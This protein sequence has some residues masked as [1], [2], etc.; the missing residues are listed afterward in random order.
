MPTAKS[1]GHP[2]AALMR[3]K[4]GAFSLNQLVHNG[5]TSKPFAICHYTVPTLFLFPLR[6]IID[7]YFS[8]FFALFLP[9][10]IDIHPP[11][12]RPRLS[13]YPV[14][15]LSIRVYTHADQTIDLHVQ[16]LYTYIIR[17]TINRLVKHYESLCFLDISPLTSVPVW[18]R[19]RPLHRCCCCV[20][21]FERVAQ[22]DARGQPRLG[23]DCGPLPS[24]G[25]SA[26]C[27]RR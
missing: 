1:G 14:L 11:M 9:L 5:N 13:I 19:F 10:Y 2:V 17:H 4:L 6:L 21:F 7:F 18:K 15:Y 24:G 23:A 16:Y 3:E 20:S 8:S 12:C 26:G 25:P 22:A 27:S